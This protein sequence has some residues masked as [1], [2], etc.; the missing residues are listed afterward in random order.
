VNI[1]KLFENLHHLQPASLQ[2]KN[3]IVI[4]IHGLL[5]RGLTMYKL[6][7]FLAKSGYEIYI[8]DYFTSAKKIDVHSSDFMKYV[9]N[10]IDQHPLK[11]IN[12]IGHSMGNIVTRDM[13][14]KL[15]SEHPEKAKQINKIIML[16][17][18]NRGSSVAKR[19]SE[20]LPFTKKLLKP[21]EELSSAK[22]STI[23]DIYDPSKDFKVGIIAGRYDGKVSVANTRLPS[24]AYEHIIINT[25]HS[26]ILY[27]KSTHKAVLNF[28]LKGKF[29]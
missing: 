17:P 29:R 22:N 8:Y 2:D 13:L 7:S 21:L 6:G 3:E 18:P 25:T 14:R 10:I 27:R 5:L 15:K 12:I 9:E 24:D 11:K 23:H 1:K 4:L 20:K 26:M 16:A 28:L 19:L